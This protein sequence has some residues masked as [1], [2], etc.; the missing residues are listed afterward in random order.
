MMSY[1]LGS[2]SGKVIVIDG[3]M[4]GDAPYLRRF[5][6]ARGNHVHAWFL[7]HPHPD[8]VDAL[9]A[10]LNDPRDLKI[11]T[12]YGSLPS[13]DW[14]ARHEPEPPACLHSVQAFN[15]AL[16]EA[17]RHVVE[18]CLGQA[19][20]I[21]GV[22]IEVLGV[23][24]PEITSNAL[25]NSSVVLRVSDEAKS[26]LFLGDLGVEGGEKLLR[27]PYRSR[28]HVDYVQ[29]GHHGQAGVNEALYQVVRPT[30]CLWPTP[31]WLW[32]NDSGGGKGSGPWRTLEVRAWMKK[33]NVRRDCVSA[34]GL[35]RID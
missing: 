9:T 3:G 29:M 11:D 18:L 35:C 23:K 19:I 16:R 1:V 21:D 8:H 27:S 26:V 22:R 4:T 32:D 17:G 33:L 25:N 15:R 10:I 13:E 20:E 7:S 24:N 5:L 14:V 12:I 34:D 30:Y 2:G 6:A 28:L 31:R